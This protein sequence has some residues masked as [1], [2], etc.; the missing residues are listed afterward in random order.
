MS[1]CCRS[2]DSRREL[3]RWALLIDPVLSSPAQPFS[4]LA[5]GA[6]N[7]IDSYCDMTSNSAADGL[8]LLLSGERT[9]GLGAAAVG[10]TC[11]FPSPVEQKLPVFET[12]RGHGE[13]WRVATFPTFQAIEPHPTHDLLECLEHW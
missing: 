11:S 10:A 8:E 4:S 3:R 12:I 1:N 5:V 2:G 6:R 7:R 9:S 13:G